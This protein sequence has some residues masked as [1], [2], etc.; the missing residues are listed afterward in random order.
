MLD[1]FNKYVD[2]ENSIINFG[3]FHIGRANCGSLFKLPNNLTSSAPHILPFFYPSV[4]CD[5][6][7]NSDLAFSLDIWRL[8]WEYYKQNKMTLK[9]IDTS[10]QSLFLASGFILDHPMSYICMCH[11]L[12]ISI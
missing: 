8:N 7:S 3:H 11:I 2:S 1:I 12:Y 10:S 4:K 5:I 6:H 9:D